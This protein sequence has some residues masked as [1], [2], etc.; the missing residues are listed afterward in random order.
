MT[1]KTYNIIYTNGKEVVLN[2]EDELCK[3]VFMRGLARRANNLY[4][5]EINHNGKDPCMSRY[6][7]CIE[8]VKSDITKE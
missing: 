3:Y 1:Q 5:L 2:G 6:V 7:G 8:E 4:D